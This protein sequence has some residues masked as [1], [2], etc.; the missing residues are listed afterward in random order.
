MPQPA[1][2][3][4]QM[5]THQV[6][7]ARIFPRLIGP[8][9]ELPFGEL[10]AALAEQ[11]IPLIV[12]YELAHYSSQ[13]GL[14]DWDGLQW[15]LGTHPDLPIILPRIGLALD[16]LLLPLMARYPN[17]YVETSY[18][19]GHGGLKRLSDAV[20]PERLLFGTGM[21]AYAPGPAITLLTYSGLDEHAKRVIGGANLAR[22]L[23]V[24]GRA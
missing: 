3:V 18:Y 21:P 15:A 8:L 1:E 20:G 22:L 23:G 16:R 11:R 5:R 17:L 2:L 6:R 7:A 12:D 4:A 10:F 14:I 13:L 9:R 24:E 19:N